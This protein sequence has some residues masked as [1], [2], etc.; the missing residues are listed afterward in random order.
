MSEPTTID[1]HL[2]APAHAQELRVDVAPTATNGAEPAPDL[3]VLPAEFATIAAEGQSAI[4]LPAVPLISTGLAWSIAIALVTQ[5]IKRILDAL[6]VPE[7][8]GPLAWHK[9]MFVVPSVVGISMT[10]VYGQELVFG[11]L[12]V[13]IGR[14][15][16]AILGFGGGVLAAWCFKLWDKFFWPALGKLLPEAMIAIADK[17]FSVS[18]ATKTAL[19]E[20]GA[21]LT[22]DSE[23][24]E[25][26]K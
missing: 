7:K 26:P 3:A 17:I 12:G 11:S 10:V 6:S 19:R 5:G 22:A 20:Q 16:A 15:A 13:Q 25:V 14:G 1:V 23:V 2:F 8:L 9:W 18:D 24:V 4:V 21:T